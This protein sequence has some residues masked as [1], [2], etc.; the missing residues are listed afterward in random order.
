[1]IGAMAP[2]LPSLPLASRV[3]GTPFVDRL[4]GPQQC[5]PHFG[6]LREY[7]HRCLACGIDG[8]LTIDHVIPVSK[9]GPNT[10]DNVQPLCGPCNSSK[11]TNTIDYRPEAA[12]NQRM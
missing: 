9:G 4:F 1:M 8:A 7:E 11:G 3:L 5:A 10:A 6:G 2:L 12:T